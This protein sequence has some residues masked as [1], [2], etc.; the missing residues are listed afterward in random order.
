MES[1]N[2]I[3]VGH[4]E[5]IIINWCTKIYSRRNSTGQPVENCD[6]SAQIPLNMIFTILLQVDVKH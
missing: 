2:E 5:I 4:K 6:R 1:A 3:H